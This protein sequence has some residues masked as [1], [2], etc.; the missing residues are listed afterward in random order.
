MLVGYSGVHVYVILNS[1][2]TLSKLEIPL[3]VPTAHT[4]THADTYPAVLLVPVSELANPS[5]WCFKWNLCQCPGL[6]FRTNWAS[7]PSGH[8]WLYRQGRAWG[9]VTQYCWLL[10]PTQM[11]YWPERTGM[12]DR[13]TREWQNKRKWGGKRMGKWIRLSNGKVKVR[14]MQAG[15]DTGIA[16]ASWSQ[17]FS[18]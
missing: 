1:C 7:S 6:V 3:S 13:D 5:P 4:I 11:I 9:G 17:P 16:K 8:V 15:V 10:S 18:G 14:T 12:K 2:I